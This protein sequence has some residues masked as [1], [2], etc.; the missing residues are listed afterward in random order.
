MNK[1]DVFAIDKAHYMPVFA[2]Y[3]MVISHGEGAYV[4]DTDGN[5]YLDFFA[6]IA[7]NARGDLVHTRQRVKNYH[8]AL[9]QL[10]L[11]LIENVAVLQSQIILLVGKSFA[12]NS[13]HIEN[14]QITDNVFKGGALGVR[15]SYVL[16]VGLLYKAGQFKLLGG[17]KDEAHVLI[18][19]HSRDE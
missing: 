12:L 9:C 11:R 10:H 7:V 6:G 15:K 1:Q 4:T 18:S 8:I 3:P 17:D 14:I 2:R 5:R 19:G 16:D 13:R